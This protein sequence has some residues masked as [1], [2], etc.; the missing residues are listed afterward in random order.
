MSSNHQTWKDQDVEQIV[1]NLLRAGVLLSAFIVA[2]G[3]AFYLYRHGKEE[4]DYGNFQLQPMEF[5]T[6]LGILRSA[7]EFSGRALIQLGLLV[8]IATPVARVAFSV[9]A[10]IRERDG[11]YVVITLIVLAVLLFSLF[12]GHT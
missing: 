5:R 3:G 10:F 2:I 1:G 6:P 8:L 9:Y 4:T 12:G 11:T 7:S